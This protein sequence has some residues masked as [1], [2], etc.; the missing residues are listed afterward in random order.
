MTRYFFSGGTMPST[1]LF[2]YFQD[3]LLLE[4]Q[5]AVNG[6]HYE[7]TANAWIDNMVR[8]KASIMPILTETYGPKEA[9][10][11]WMYW[12]VFFMACAELW[13]YAHGTEWQVTHYLFKKR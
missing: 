13:G 4:N 8:H 5:W 6:T 9:K 7:K 10:K 11:W 3:D 2:H 1:D 12:K